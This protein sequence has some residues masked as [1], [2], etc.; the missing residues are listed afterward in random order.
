M[1]RHFHVILASLLMAVLFVTVC[2]STVGV[3]S[4]SA[5]PG[6]FKFTAISMADNSDN[7]YKGQYQAWDKWT[8]DN[9]R[10]VVRGARASSA[11]K[12]PEGTE[13]LMC[14]EVTENGYLVPFLVHERQLEQTM[15]TLTDWEGNSPDSESVILVVSVGEMPQA[16]QDAAHQ[17]AQD[18]RAEYFREIPKWLVDLLPERSVLLPNGEIVARIALS[19]LGLSDETAQLALKQEPD[20]RPYRDSDSTSGWARF[21]SAG[22]LL[23]YTRLGHWWYLY[24]DA[25][26]NPLPAGEVHMQPDGYTVIRSLADKSL[27]ATYDYDGT[28]LDTPPGAP[29]DLHYFS[30]LMPQILVQCYDAQQRT[31][32]F[33]TGSAVT[34][35]AK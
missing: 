35:S 12:G 28:R 22:K 30:Q 25:G 23:G 17:A 34:S 26:A 24:F 3:K 15:T 20:R 29:R 1:A 9:Q 8:F 16:L 6:G 2:G 19:K 5:V 4:S 21:D 13:M 18:I 14:S 10:G 27:I 32:K 31:H 33:I 7:P 11:I